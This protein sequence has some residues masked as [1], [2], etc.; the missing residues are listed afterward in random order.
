MNHVCKE[1]AHIVILHF[2]KVEALGEIEIATKLLEDDS[3]DEV[4]SFS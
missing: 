3:S 1:S 2:F 4:M